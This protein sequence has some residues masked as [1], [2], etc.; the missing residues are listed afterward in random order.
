MERVIGV[1][2]VFFR[3]AAPEHLRQWYAEHLGIPDDGYGHRFVDDGPLVWAPFPSDTVY[4]PA[5]QQ[6][7]VNYRVGDLDLILA[8]LRAA[9]VR[10]EEHVQDESFGRFGWAYDPDG[11]KFELWQAGPAG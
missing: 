2:G 7:M 8:Q 5:E 9:G 4:F 6:H 3:S 11:V 10:V 1:G